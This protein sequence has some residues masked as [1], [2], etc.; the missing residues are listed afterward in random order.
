[1]SSFSGVIDY[2]PPT[3]AVRHGGPPVSKLPARL[4]PILF[5]RRRRRR[6]RVDKNNIVPRSLSIKIISCTAR[7]PIFL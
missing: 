7:T 2:S 4:Q 5:V 6:R 3:R 1:M